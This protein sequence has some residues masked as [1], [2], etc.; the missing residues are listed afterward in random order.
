MTVSVS[1][2]VIINIGVITIGAV[3]MTVH[4]LSLT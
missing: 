1:L 3:K 4:C 2:N